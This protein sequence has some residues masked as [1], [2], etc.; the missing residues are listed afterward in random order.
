MTAT[1]ATFCGVFAF[2]GR[3][4]L[5]HSVRVAARA[6]GMGLGSLAVI[7]ATGA[8]ATLGAAWLFS[9]ALSASPHARSSIGPGVF[10]HDNRVAARAGRVDVALRRPMLALVT[11]DPA[12]EAESASPAVATAEDTPPPAIVARPAPLPPPRLAL[13]PK[14]AAENPGTVPL[15]RPHP[16]RQETAPQVAAVAPPVAAPPPL[17]KPVPPQP[18][19]RSKALALAGGDA[20]TAVY[21][22]SA[23]A[24]Y[25]PNGETLEAHSGFGDKMDDPRFI[26]VRMQGPTPPNVYDLALREKLFHGVQAIR[27]KP[28]DESRMF[29]RDGMLA[30]SYLLGPNGQSN[31][32]VSFKDYDKFLNAFLDGQVDRLVVVAHIDDAPPA[33]VARAP[34]RGTGRFAAAAM[35]DMGK[36]W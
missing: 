8:A 9:A 25:L 7:G 20:R 19:V 21:D 13:A 17:Q 29:G 1:T 30:H 4:F 32:C 3:R 18:S 34:R 11:P 26:K 14:P 5:R 36:T 33:L 23:R 24:V 28:L 35:P 2:D 10:V 16:A 31:G 27:L 15:P 22:I 12:S 6:A